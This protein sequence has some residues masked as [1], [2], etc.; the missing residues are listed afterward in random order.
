MRGVIGT[1]EGL[2][3]SAVVVGEKV[4]SRERLWVLS[5]LVRRYSELLSFSS[6]IS[7]WRGAVDDMGLIYKFNSL[8]PPLGDLILWTH[9]GDSVWICIDTFY[10]HHLFVEPP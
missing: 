3:E 8:P 1:L 7:S 4:K 5:A 9:R 2:P 10:G 6:N